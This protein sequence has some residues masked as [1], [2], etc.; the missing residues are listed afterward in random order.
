MDAEVE[1]SKQRQRRAE[2]EHHFALA[3]LQA[4]LKHA[5]GE[6][7]VLRAGAGHAKDQALS[8]LKVGLLCLKCRGPL[9]FRQAFTALKVACICLG[10]R[11]CLP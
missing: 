3:A 4:Q 10:G 8:A 2:Q 1:N 11:L 9:H 7:E 5:A 6:M